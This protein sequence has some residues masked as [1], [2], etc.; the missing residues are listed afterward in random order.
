MVRACLAARVREGQAPE[1]HRGGPDASS[2]AAG[3]RL[4]L[5]GDRPKGR[6]PSSIIVLCF[7]AH[8][9]VSP[10]SSLLFGNSRDSGARGRI[11][12]PGPLEFYRFSTVLGLEN[13]FAH[14]HKYRDGLPLYVCPC[15]SLQTPGI[16]PQF[17][18]RMVVA[19]H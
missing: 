1:D 18:P 7:E 8:A 5:A 16:M 11:S 19:S 13:R 17:P 6:V 4:D 3:W 15:S 2:R 10:P 9:G 14:R 12:F